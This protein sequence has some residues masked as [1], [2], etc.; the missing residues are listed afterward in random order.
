MAWYGVRNVY[1]F[2]INSNGINVF[3]ERIVSIEA[4]N[5][6]AAHEK[7]K[8]ESDLYALE[9]GFESHDEQLVYRQ[10]G[11]TL[12]DGYEVWSELYEANL[13]LDLF[14]SEKYEKYLYYPENA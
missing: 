4:V 1:L 11:D 3:E 9:N 2:G 6:E 14:Y 12:I 10:D 7:G 13:S 5:D 8:I